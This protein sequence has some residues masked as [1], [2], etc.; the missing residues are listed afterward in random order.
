MYLE[1]L[2]EIVPIDYL[3]TNTIYD[4]IETKEK[5]VIEQTWARIINEVISNPESQY[6]NFVKTIVLKFDSQY[7]TSEISETYSYDFTTIY[8]KLDKKRITETNIGDENF[9]EN[10]NDRI[11]LDLIKLEYGNELYLEYID[12]LNSF[13]KIPFEVVYEFLME[14]I[15]K[16]RL[17]WYGKNIIKLV[18]KK[19]Q[20]D[21]EVKFSSDSNLNSIQIDSKIYYPTYKNIYNYAKSISIEFIEVEKGVQVTDARTLNLD[22]KKLFIQIIN[23]EKNIN[24]NISNVLKKTYGLQA[25]IRKIQ[26]F[27]VEYFLSNLK[28]IVFTS[29]IQLGLLNRFEIDPSITDED[30]LGDTE[31]SRKINI[32]KKI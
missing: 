4:I 2:D 22:Q 10:E 6:S 17:T 16:F 11:V 18:D 1:M 15:Q 12:K 31:T 26:D 8:T 7:C 23:R 28:D 5:K 19:Y 13:K 3:C 27:I 14:Q 21:S 30:L 20:I 9:L 25:P 29:W 32:K 24:F